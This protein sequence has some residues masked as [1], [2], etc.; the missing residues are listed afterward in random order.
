MDA[1]SESGEMRSARAR[2]GAP[3]SASTAFMPTVRRSVLLPD[4]FEPLTSSRP[5]SRSR[6]TSLRTQ[7][8]LGDQRMAEAEPLEPR[9]FVDELRER[10]GRMLVGVAAERAQGLDLADR[11][12]PD[13]HARPHP[14]AP[15]LDRQG[16]LRRPEQRQGER[17]E[18]LVPPRFE[19]LLQSS[20][21]PHLQRRGQAVRVQPPSQRD[22]RRRREALPLQA[23]ED[24]REQREIAARPIRRLHGALDTRVAAGG[25]T[26]PASASATISGLGP[27]PRH[28]ASAASTSSAASAAERARANDG[29]P[30]GGAVAQL[31]SAV[32][33]HAG[34]D[35]LAGESEVLAQVEARAQLQHGLLP[36]ARLA[37]RGGAPQ[38]VRERLLPRPGARRAEKLEE[39]AATEEIQVRRV[40]VRVVLEALAR[41]ARPGPAV[42]DAREALS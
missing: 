18:Q 32:G 11:R 7:T 41:L 20:Q 31:R 19:Q 23:R 38:P 28:Q 36:R 37:H 8:R 35:V 6:R 21:A 30:A 24:R 2:T 34:A 4:M 13:R 25:P 22:E 3:A 10:V 40:R 12:E 16:E 15:G 29:K 39:R 1:P 42:L 17:R 14:Q 5:C 26:I 27:A 33:S 9:P